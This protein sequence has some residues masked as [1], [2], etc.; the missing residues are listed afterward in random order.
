MISFP[1]QYEPGSRTHLGVHLVEVVVG[2]NQVFRRVD[3]SPD[4]DSHPYFMMLITVPTKTDSRGF[5]ITGQNLMLITNQEF[6]DWGVAVQG[7]APDTYVMG[8][9]PP[10]LAQVRLTVGDA[11]DFKKAATKHLQNLAT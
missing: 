1:Y 6:L 3:G 7:L 9:L 2:R 5:L 10:R 8:I 4:Q 11:Q